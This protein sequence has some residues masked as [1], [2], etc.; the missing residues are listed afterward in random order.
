MAKNKGGRP[1]VI[2]ETVLKKLE[3][4]FANGASD[5]EACFYAGISHQTLYNYQEKHPEFVERKNGLKNMLKYQ[6]KVNIAKEI[7][8]KNSQMQIN[9][10]YLERK[11]KGEFGNSLKITTEDEAASDTA[12]NEFL[13]ENSGDTKIE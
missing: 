8:K 3:E 2:T 1:T 6:A 13:N 9:T 10:W 12:L 4:A 7:R 5:D 11:E